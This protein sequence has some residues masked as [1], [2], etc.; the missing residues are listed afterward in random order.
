METKVKQ[1][2][3]VMHKGA[4][5]RSPDTPLSE[6]AKLMSEQDVGAIPIGEN[7]KMIGMVTDRDMVCRG[8]SN[9]KDLSTLKARDVMSKGIFYCS[10]DEDIEEAVQM[11]QKNKIRRLPVINGKKRLVGMLSIGDLSHA[12]PSK[13]TSDLVAAVADHHA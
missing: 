3:E 6:I 12:A 5:W 1:V 13:L 8:F 9:G 4:E 2:K 10:E 7:D 11:M